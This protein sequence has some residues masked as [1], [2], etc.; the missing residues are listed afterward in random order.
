[1]KYDSYQ[2]SGIE[3]LGDIPSHWQ[4]L[5]IKVITQP[6]SIK[7][8]S[9]EELLSVYRDYGVIIKNSRDDNHNKTGEN[10]NNY[11][12]VEKTNLVLN[13][14]KTWQG[15]LGVSEYQG[16]VS[17]A[18]IVCKIDV[19]R[20]FPKFLN[21]L[22]RCKNYIFEYNRLS[23]GVRNEQWDMRYDDFKNIPLF[24][25]PKEEQKAIADFLDKKLESINNYISKQKELIEL[26]KEKKNSLINQAVTKGIDNNV[27]YIDSG[28]E[29][30]GKIPKH[31]E[32]IKIKRLCHVKRGASPR[33]ID[34]PR[35]FDDN[36]EYS[37]VRIADVTKSDK[38]LYETTQK[39]SKIGS[40]KSVK[41]EPNRIFLS[42]A[43]SIG[44]PII[45]RI[46]CCIHDGFVWFDRLKKDIDINFFYYIFLNGEAYKGLGKLGTQLNLNTDTVGMI[47]V[48][49]TSLA[50]QKQIVNY[51][52]KE[53]KKIDD[54]ISN[55]EDELKLL[56][57]YK[58]SIISSAVTGKIKVF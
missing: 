20:I 56:D 3:W 17:P 24:L 25:P 43:G 4:V 6:K 57:E 12:F 35:Y 28:I 39:M 15:S 54:V 32:V 52:E 21:H 53:S 31:W 49:I 13:K 11:K 36:G 27:E 41:L 48:P 19:S 58:Q 22:L 44:K 47:T 40:L 38:Y 29:W 34:D 2:A 1:M 33:P 8:K 45:S 51:I 14:M 10:L 16:I 55:I 42:I 18:Y 46:K 26:L 50:E 37:W 30:L 9:K 23:Y 5:S 7:N